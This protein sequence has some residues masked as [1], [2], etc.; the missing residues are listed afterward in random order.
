[1]RV[2]FAVLVSLLASF[3]LVSTMMFSQQ[4]R[5]E[6]H[7][8]HASP[9]AARQNSGQQ[10]SQEPQ[11]FF[12]MADQPEMEMHHHGEIPEAR[13]HFPRLGK[14]HRLVTSPAYPSPDF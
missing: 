10:P 7:N 1:M 4:P 8:E 2:R 9:S 14:S 5:T 6:S 13:P 3:L 11:E 12:P